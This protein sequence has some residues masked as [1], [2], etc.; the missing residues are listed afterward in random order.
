MSIKALEEKLEQRRFV[1]IH[2]SYIVAA[3]KITAIKRD[4]V[5]IGSIELPL[6]GNYKTDLET[7]LS[8]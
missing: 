4:L 5:Y 2:K 6:S 7:M 1:R 8:L 3:D